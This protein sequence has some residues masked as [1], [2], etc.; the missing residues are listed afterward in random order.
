MFGC[1]CCP[2]NITRFIASFADFL[3]TEDADT[4][5]V[6]HYAC[7]RTQSIEMTTEY[8]VDGKIALRLRG[9][10][11][12]RA[13]LRIPGWCGDFTCGAPGEL[14]R[15]Y[16]YLNIPGDDF[17]NG[18]RRRFAP[19]RMLGTVELL[20]HLDEPAILAFTRFF[21]ASSDFDDDIGVT[22]HGYAVCLVNVGE[23]NRRVGIAVDIE[24]GFGVADI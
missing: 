15:G 13:A 14:D 9:M 8:P 3:F 5:Y 22:P 20:G 1:S 2:P 21:G 6:H 19:Y 23:M 18:Y 24:D 7:A 16:Y 12:K 17:A 10:A 11:G 4:L